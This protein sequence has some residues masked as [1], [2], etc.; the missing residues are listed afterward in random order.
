MRRSERNCVQRPYAVACVNFY[1]QGLCQPGTNVEPSSFLSEG[2]SKTFIQLTL[3]VNCKVEWDR[4]CCNKRSYQQ[5]SGRHGHTMALKRSLQGL[6]RNF[7]YAK[8]FIKAESRSFDVELFRESISV[9]S[10]VNSLLAILFTGIMRVCTSG[11]LVYSFSLKMFPSRP[12]A[13]DA[14]GQNLPAPR[15]DAKGRHE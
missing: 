11:Q 13:P 3:F 12:M 15:S 14:A 1:N 8:R 5:L 7:Q 9:V 2:T 4:E 6:A 10:R